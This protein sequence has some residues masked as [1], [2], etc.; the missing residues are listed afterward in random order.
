LC[1]DTA[2]RWSEYELAKR[3]QES[4]SRAKIAAEL[5][6]HI[7]LYRDYGYSSEYLQGMERARLLVLFDKSLKL[8][9][10]SLGDQQTLF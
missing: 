4:E 9:K 7:D 1:D 10:E 6:K 8:D 3:Q 5:Q 2:V